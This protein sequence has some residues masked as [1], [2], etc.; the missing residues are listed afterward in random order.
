MLFNPKHEDRL[1]RLAIE[2]RSA[3]AV[4]PALFSHVI[5]EACTRLPVLSRAAKAGRMD[6]LINAGAWTEA[7][8][9]AIELELPAWKLR[10]LVLE[11]GE[12][13]C[14]L[15]RQPNLPVELDDTAE[16]C[17]EI[18]ALAILSALVEARCCSAAEQAPGP[19]SVPQVRPETG[20]G[21]C[22][23]NFA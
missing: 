3:Q 22:C 2:L 13:I 10:R 12:W 6:Q 21:V 17:H 23:D 14:C 8:L 1:G 9:A 16:G 19:R 5:A 18:M 20:C 7:A 4:T 11:D 15:S